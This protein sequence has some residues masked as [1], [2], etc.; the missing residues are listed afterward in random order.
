MAETQ[1][2]YVIEHIRGHVFVN[3]MNLYACSHTLWKPT[4]STY[5][6][7]TLQVTIRK[8]GFERRK[9]SAIV[10]CSHICMCTRSFFIYSLFVFKFNNKNTW[11]PLSKAHSTSWT[12]WMLLVY[13]FS[14]LFSCSSVIFQ[15]LIVLIFTS[16]AL[17]LLV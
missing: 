4:C 9:N 7:I 11:M 2:N 10:C 6:L 12:I 14:F 15:E 3:F 5:R 13:F 8:T 1:A 16:F 17:K